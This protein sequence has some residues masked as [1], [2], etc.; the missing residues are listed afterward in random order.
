VQAQIELLRKVLAEFP[1]ASYF[2]VSVGHEA[3]HRRDV[4]ESALISYMRQVRIKQG[5]FVQTVWCYLAAS[6]M[7]NTLQIDASDASGA[8]DMS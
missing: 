4:S 5:V 2:A 8:H 6:C 7:H 3:L 1:D